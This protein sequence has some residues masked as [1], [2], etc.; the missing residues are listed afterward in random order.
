MNYLTCII[1]K[2]EGFG[3][4]FQYILSYY[5]LSKKYGLKFFYTDIKNFEH[6]IWDGYDS[7]EKWDKMLNE[8]IKKYLLLDDI[9]IDIDSNINKVYNIYDFISYSN[10]LFIFNQEIQLEKCFCYSEINNT[11]VN[12][13]SD[14]YLL[15]NQQTLCY[16]DKNKINIALHIRTFTI[17]DC[18][19]SSSRQYY[20]KGNS[21]DYYYY[22]SILN[23]KNLFPE[24]KLEFHIFTQIDDTNKNS[25]DHYLE[26]KDDN[27]NIVIHKGNDMTSDLYHLITANI[28][29]LSRSSFSEIVNYYTKNVCLVRKSGYKNKTL[30][31][32]VLL[33]NDN[34]KLNK[35][36]K[37]YI[38]NNYLSKY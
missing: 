37:E 23:I 13:L 4:V 36:Q 2:P 38:L 15:K 35:I 24:E 16:Y 17:T 12:I 7:Q 20:K 18:D 30:K 29:F 5:L 32:N 21:A 9:V 34:G 26:L 27:T 14:N 19:S 31:S 6:M 11:Q 25:F 1:T 28:I 8:Y 33:L 22:N 3:S 10:T